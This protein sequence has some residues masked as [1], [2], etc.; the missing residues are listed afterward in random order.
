[1]GRM[2]GKLLI[3]GILAVAVA[4]ATFA[5]RYQQA[6][7]YR[8][9]AAL[10]SPA[11]VLIRLAPEI[12]LWQL[13]RVEASVDQSEAWSL[14]GVD[15]G[16]VD[17]RDL[18]HGS[19]IVHARQALIEDRSYVWGHV[20]QVPNTWTHALRFRRDDQ[21]TILWF[22][23]PHGRVRCDRRADTLQLNPAV[24]AGF[25][26]YFVEQLAAPADQSSTAE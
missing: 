7:G 9:L 20:E 26:D 3:L 15:Y 12:E 6:R 10:G 19:G 23:L 13:E 8:V 22:D 21:E 11:A 25:Q 2:N 16:V 5:W 24:T 17:Q 14:D 4:A 1:M 18:S